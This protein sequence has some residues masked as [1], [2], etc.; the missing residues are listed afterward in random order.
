M[1]TRKCGAYAA[2]AAVLLVSAVLITNC[3][4]PVNPG[5]LTVPK[6]NEQTTFVVPAGKEYIQLNVNIESFARTA[7]PTPIY[8]VWGDFGS[9]EVVITGAAAGNVNDVT[10][11]TWNG[12]A[13]IGVAVDTYAVKVIG[14]DI[15]DTDNRVAVAYGELTGIGV[16]SGAGVSRSITLKEITTGALQGTGTFKYTLTDSSTAITSSMELIGLT[17]GATTAH[18]SGASGAAIT[19]KSGTITL[20][21]GYYRME[22]SLTRTNYKSATIREIIHIWN[23]HETEYE[24]T[25]SLNSTLHTVTYHFND[26]RTATPSE[27]FVHGATFTIT[28]AA[29]ASPQFSTNAG[30]TTFDTGRAFQ[31]WFEDDD[32]WLK[33]WT[34]GTTK[35]IR[36]QFLYAKWSAP[37]QSI[38]LAVTIQ[39]S[40]DTEIE[41]DLSDDDIGAITDLDTYTIDQENAPEI[42][43]AITSDTIALLDTPTYQWHYDQGALSGSTT[44]SS[45]TVDFADLDLIG[46]H[47]FTVLVSEGGVQKWSG[48][49]TFTVVAP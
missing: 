20:A 27:T 16:A 18:N 47:T 43:I 40:G 39:F 45:I 26:T 21:S 48:H 41:F 33:Q 25:L 38:T 19:N 36:P 9:T 37:S 42:T 49:V 23:G 3:I 4:D 11:T 22:I 31:G 34:D 12:A 13:A 35:V 29:A 6:D 1:K 28:N 17:S 14:Y 10:L 5:G 2:M 15:A 30:G 7:V 46:S 8:A 32:T 24:K 44:G